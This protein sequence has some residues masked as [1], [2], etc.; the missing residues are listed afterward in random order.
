MISIIISSVSKTQLNDVSANIAATI[1]VP[2]EIIATDNSNGEKGICEVYNSAAQ[3]AQYDIIC[4]MHEDVIIK[5]IN[6]G[7]VVQHIF[8]G[9]DSIG[10]AGIVGSTYK[11]LMPS[12]WVCYGLHELLHYN[13]IQSFKRSDTPTKHEYN[14]PDN[15]KLTPVACVD[16][17]WFCTTKKVVAEIKFDEK[18]LTGFH[19]YD[20]DFSLAVN[21]KYKVVV[22]YD[23]LLNHLSEGG[24]ERDWLLDTLK[25]HDKWKRN[26]PLHIANIN[27]KQRLLIEWQTFKVF[28]RQ[29]L[30]FKLSPYKYRGVFLNA[31]LKKLG[32]GRTLKLYY[33][34]IK[35]R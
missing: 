3:R 9:D 20:I 34:L 12:G 5:T 21:Q 25:L 11:S 19:G 18:L 15:E 1:G 13:I 10:L 23:V 35:K 17:V 31:S 28:M 32:I 24:F 16:G 2:Y 26:L 30:E 27:K 22:T 8:A 33:Y 29:M 6:W 7:E 4:F 14:N